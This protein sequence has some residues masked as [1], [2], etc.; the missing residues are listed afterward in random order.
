MFRFGRRRGVHHGGYL[1]GS[2]M[3]DGCGDRL[4][5]AGPNCRNSNGELS[6]LDEA[7]RLRSRDTS[8]HSRNLARGAV[9]TSSSSVESRCICRYIAIRNNG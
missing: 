7:D 9:R 2:G 8:R 5:G 1:A 6:V 4:A 3:G